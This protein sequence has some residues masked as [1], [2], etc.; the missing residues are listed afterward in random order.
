MK[1]TKETLLRRYGKR[2]MMCGKRYAVNYLRWHHI[3]P[4]YVS[5][6]NHEP[7]DDS[8]DN[9]AILCVSCH[10]MIHEYLWWED[11]YQLLTEIILQNKAS[12]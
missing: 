9:G 6:A 10:V 11:E 2:C 8:V 12:F 7:P 4:K 3:L 1:L 5:K